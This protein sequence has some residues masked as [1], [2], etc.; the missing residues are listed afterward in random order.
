M[1]D[2]KSQNAPIYIWHRFSDKP[3]C[4]FGESAKD[5]RGSLT[6]VIEN[7]SEHPVY[8]YVCEFHKDLATPS[9]WREA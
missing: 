9:R 4:N 3:A 2:S 5:C 6:K 8:A 7:T 1:Q